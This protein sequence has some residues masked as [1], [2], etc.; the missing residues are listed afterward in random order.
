MAVIPALERWLRNEF[1]G[2]NILVEGQIKSKYN[3]YADLAMVQSKSNVIHTY[4]VKTKINPQIINSIVW[5]L[6]SFYANYRWLVIPKNEYYST[7][8]VY[9]VLRDNGIGIILF[10]GKKHYSFNEKLKAKYIDGNFIE[11]WPQLCATWY[12]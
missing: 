7:S 11:Y 12:W 10:S 8:G 3:Q 9:S 1:S 4:E 5:A 6:S 2:F